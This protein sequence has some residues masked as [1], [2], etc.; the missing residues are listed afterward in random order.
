MLPPDRERSKWAEKIHCEHV[1]KLK[2]QHYVWKFEPFS[3]DKPR[4]VSTGA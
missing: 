1:Q 2:D 4:V 3:N